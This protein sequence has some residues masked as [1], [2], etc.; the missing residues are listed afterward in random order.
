MP[1]GSRLCQALQHVTYQFR[2]VQALYRQV[3]SQPLQHFKH[4]DQRQGTAGVEVKIM[5]PFKHVTCAEDT[6]IELRADS[7]IQSW[8]KERQDTDI[9]MHR[10]ALWPYRKSS[11][12]KSAEWLQGGRS[13]EAVK[14]IL[15]QS[16]VV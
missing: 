16:C 8:I 7:D 11:V 13:H 15:F 2:P 14:H 3:I 4:A 5:Q 12:L 9:Q 6:N 1:A 10:C